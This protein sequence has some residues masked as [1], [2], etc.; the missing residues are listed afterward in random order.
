M[1][2][3]IK[4][5]IDKEMKTAIDISRKATLD[6]LNVF[7]QELVQAVAKTVVETVNGKVDKANKEIEKITSILG[8]QDIILQG[9]TDI[10]KE[11]KPVLIEFQETTI[12]KKLRDKWYKII[13]GT[14]I[15]LGSVYFLAQLI[16]KLGSL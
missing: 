5:Y 10:L 13:L 4:K 11:V 1:E 16:I 6:V 8:A 12:E 15:F 2:V 7:K 9:H 3:E 14:P